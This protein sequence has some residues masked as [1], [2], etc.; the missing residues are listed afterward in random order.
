MLLCSIY[1]LINLLHIQSLVW[2]MVVFGTDC[3]LYFTQDND[4]WLVWFMVFNATFNNISVISWGSV[5]LEEEA[6]ENNRPVASHWQPF[7]HNVVEYTSPWTGFELTTL[8][9]VGTDCTGSCKSNYHT[10][11][12]TTAPLH[13]QAKDYKNGIYYFFSDKHSALRSKNK[14]WL[15]MKQDNVSE[16]SAMKI[17]V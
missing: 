14:D 16:W 13:I 10:I 15:R 8:V 9:V 7:S 11:M 17:S 6:G 5:L 3:Q 4:C 2:F 12:A 1:T